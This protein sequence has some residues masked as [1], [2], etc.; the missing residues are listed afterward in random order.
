MRLCMRNLTLDVIVHHEVDTDFFLR[1]P[2][3]NFEFYSRTWNRFVYVL[4]IYEASSQIL[5]R[6]Y[7]RKGET[8]EIMLADPEENVI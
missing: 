7:L 8:T 5:D 3:K 6:W 2:G 1:V 4:V